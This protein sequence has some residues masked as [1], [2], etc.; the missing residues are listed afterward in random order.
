MQ[1]TTKL[2]KIIQDSKGLVLESDIRGRMQE[3][4][5]QLIGAINHVHKVSEVHVFVAI[6]RGFWDRMG[7]VNERSIEPS[8]LLLSYELLTNLGLGCLEFPGKPQ[9][10]QGLVQRRESCSVG[11]FIFL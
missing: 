7:Q 5:D 10:E 1:S 2:K 8:F 4:N 11:K 9:R 6:C 3:L